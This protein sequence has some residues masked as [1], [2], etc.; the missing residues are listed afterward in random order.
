MP[1]APHSRLSKTTTRRT[2]LLIPHTQRQ[3][4]IQT[5]CGEPDCGTG[6]GWLHE[7]NNTPARHGSGTCDDPEIL[8]GMDMADL[9]HDLTDQGPALLSYVAVAAA[10]SWLACYLITNEPWSII[11]STTAALWA[12]GTATLLRLHGHHSHKRRTRIKGNRPPT[13]NS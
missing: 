11:H 3:T 4:L 1:P 10:L 12:A 7:R 9:E 2:K 5:T 13:D 6:L 8:T